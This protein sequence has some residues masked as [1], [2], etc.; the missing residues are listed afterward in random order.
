MEEEV[1]TIQRE[2]QDE[3]CRG[4]AVHSQAEQI[5]RQRFNFLVAA[6]RKV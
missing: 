6:D 2:Q 3:I 1:F 4:C 5:A